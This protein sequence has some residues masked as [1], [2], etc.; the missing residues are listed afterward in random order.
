MIL[1][2]E[3]RAYL[4]ARFIEIFG[5][6][7]DDASAFVQKLQKMLNGTD[8]Q[9]MYELQYLIFK[10]KDHQYTR[11]VVH[12]L[13]DM[14]AYLYKDAA[15]EYERSDLTEYL[16]EFFNLIVIQRCAYAREMEAQSQI[17][18]H[19][20]KSVSDR[21]YAVLR[22]QERMIANLS[23]EMR[24]SLNTIQGYLSIIDD[25]GMIKGEPK[26]QLKKAL[27]GAESL[28]S[29]VKDILNITK[30]NSGQLEIE[31]SFFAVDEMLLQCIDHV[32][33]QIGKR[34]EIR[35]EY[36]A[37]FTPFLVYGDQMHMMEIII[38]FLTNAFKYTEKGFIKLA[39]DYRQESDG[40]EMT[41]SVSD[42]GVG[43]TPEQLQDVFSPYSRYQRAKQ[44]L[45][46][47]MHITK[48]LS[49]R[50][51]GR[52]DVKSQPGEGST[53]SFSIRFEKIKPY[54]LDLQG[55]KI[56]FYIDRKMQ[57]S[58]YIQEKIRF[59]KV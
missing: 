47:G 29:L 48:Q 36:E 31:K 49:K 5:G 15:N 32:A 55:K 38:N 58:F 28:Q 45:G 35:F 19:I 1:S 23:H 9:I 16:K 40:V 13:L 26:F 41:F 20:L 56:Y 33:I 53:F 39:M 24:T 52:L 37:K 11:K 7:E 22:T 59:L 4:S 30:I 2:Q 10:R 12:F 44:G 18:H 25:S 42:S 54:Q 50:L 57:D 51:G 21:L 43:M 3:N 8:R 46:L 14:F 34:E 6:C 27:H 17:S